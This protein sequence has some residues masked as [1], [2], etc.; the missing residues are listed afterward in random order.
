MILL[1]LSLSIA[2]AMQPGRQ[3]SPSATAVRRA[4]STVR[5]ACEH[6]A[7]RGKRPLELEPAARW[8]EGLSQLARELCARGPDG[9]ECH[10]ETRPMLSR[11]LAPL[12]RG[13]QSDGRVP[14][15]TSDSVPIGGSDCAPFFDRAALERAVRNHALDAGLGEYDEQEGGVGGWQLYALQARSHSRLIDSRMANLHARWQ[16]SVRSA[17]VNLSVC[18][19]MYDRSTSLWI[20]DL[21]KHDLRME[22]RLSRSGIGM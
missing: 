5:D 6:Y 11:A 18:C 2:S 9:E 21:R 4:P 14:A 17:P 10:W 20:G 13:R 12:L 8:A 19:A 1:A 7:P 16:I 22:R 15:G 3:L